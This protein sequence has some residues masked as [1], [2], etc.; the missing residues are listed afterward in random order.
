MADPNNGNEVRQYI[1]LLSVIGC[2]LFHSLKNSLEVS[3]LKLQ[4]SF[5]W[6][7]NKMCKVLLFKRNV[8]IVF[9]K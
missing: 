8:P 7:T 9:K 3:D 2:H 4:L 5:M 6:Y 1:N